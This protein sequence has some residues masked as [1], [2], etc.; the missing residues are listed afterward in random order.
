M[1]L[2]PMGKGWGSLVLQSIFS[3]LFDT[4][5]NLQ[6]EGADFITGMKKFKGLIMYSGSRCHLG[7]QVDH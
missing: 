3:L 1:V 5:Q 2:K 6:Q 7:Y 4:P